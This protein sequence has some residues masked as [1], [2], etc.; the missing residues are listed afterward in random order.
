MAQDL[1]EDFIRVAA[2]ANSEKIAGV[3]AAAVQLR[4]NPV[5]RGV[6]ASAVNQM[7]KACAIARGYVAPSGIDLHFV[8]GF[9]NVPDREDPTKEITCLTMRAVRG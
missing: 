8:P 4:R 2:G 9:A 3:I 1:E 7:V 6:G 5:C